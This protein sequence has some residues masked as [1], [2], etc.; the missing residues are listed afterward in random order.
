MVLPLTEFAPDPDWE[1]VPDPEPEEDDEPEEV[2]VAIDYSVR[3]KP[4]YPSDPAALEAYFARRKAA[5]EAAALEA[6]AAD[7][8]I[9]ITQPAEDF[10]SP[11]SALASYAKLAR[12]N[13]WEVVKMAHSKALEPGKP[14]KS[15]PKE[16]QMNPDKEIEQQWIFL[17]RGRERIIVCYEL[18]N[19][20]TVGGRTLRR[21]NGVRLG[22][23]SLKAIIKGEA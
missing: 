1:D 8:S 23:A 18:A 22:D 19:G 3:T 15:G 17:E 21:L 5:R 14:I 10:T 9:V 11:I 4:K 7:Y 6:G 20:K 12:E 2:H 16:G 13:D